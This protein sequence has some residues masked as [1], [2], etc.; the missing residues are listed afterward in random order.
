MTPEVGNSYKTVMAA[1][2]DY[3]KPPS[4]RSTWPVR[5]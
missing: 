2:I 5:M 1:L 3:I 4:K